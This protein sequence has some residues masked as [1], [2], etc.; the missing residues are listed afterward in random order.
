MRWS[1][2]FIP[3]LRDVPTD[4]QIKSHILMLRAGVIRQLAAGVYTFL[5]LGWRSMLKATRIIREEMNGIGGQEIFMPSLNPIELWDETGRSEDMGEIMYRF[6]DRKGQRFCLAPTHE[7]VIADLARGELRSY[8]ELPQIWYQFQNKFR[9]E[10]RPRSGLLRVREFIMKDSYTLCADN[11]QL[12]ESYSL[13]DKAY[14]RIFD[15]CGLKYYVVGASSGLMGGTGSEEFMVPSDAGEDI[16]A[17]CGCGFAQNLEV[18]RS[19]PSKVDWVEVE[20]KK[21]HTPG[22]RTIEEVSKFLKLPPGQMLKS[23]LYITQSG[24]PVMAC[25]RGD[26]ELSE[27][28]LQIAVGEQ[29]RPAE[30]EEAKKITGSEIGFLGPIGLE[31]KVRI[32][33][34]EAVDPEMPFATGANE[35]DYHIIGW[36][37]ADI[38]N[39]ET[40]DLRK[41][42]ENDTCANCGG[43]IKLVQTIEIGHIFK[44]GTKYSSAMGATFLDENGDAKPIVMGSYGIGVGRI[45]A[46]AIELYAD[47]D[48]ICWPIS[49]AP[50]E[51]VVTALN[52]ADEKIVTT[53]TDIYEKLLAEGIDVLFDDRDLGA[54]AKFKDADLMGAPIRVTVGRGVAKGVVEIFRRR[55]KTK[56]EVPI[57][58]A[59]NAIRRLREELFAELTP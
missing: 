35:V 13:H 55:E 34:D 33:V 27:E 26:H 56:V 20:K 19:V 18:A 32:L 24:K 54:G 11:A 58:D 2:S 38:A 5:P 45:L 21:I 29:T 39:T 59:I 53:A 52:I 42:S 50:F 31:N 15:R 46:A 36:T 43:N 37:K 1:K 40:A 30:P 17:T 28:K 48:G 12:D 8:R 49:L 44:L 14:R 57:D 41:V 51:V 3:T 16:I 10:P 6:S 25:I 47:D 22:Q 9:D 7:E 4:T 23:L